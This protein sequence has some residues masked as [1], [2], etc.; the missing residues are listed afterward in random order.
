MT[1]LGRR[2]SPSPTRSWNWLSDEMATRFVAGS[3]PVRWACVTPVGADPRYRGGGSG[4]P[5]SRCAGPRISAP[6]GAAAGRRVRSDS[7]M[8]S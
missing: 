3:G 4:R 7:P 8:R 5:P 2:A 6:A 1:W